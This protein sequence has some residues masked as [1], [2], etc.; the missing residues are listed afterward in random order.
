MTPQHLAADLG[1]DPADP[2]VL[3][4]CTNL[5]NNLNDAAAC[6]KLAGLT[7][8]EVRR[9][10]VDGRATYEEAEA[11]FQVWCVG[12]TEYRWHDGRPQRLVSTSSGREFW[13]TC[14]ALG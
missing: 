11:Y 9:W 13:V 5:S 14:S 4:T 12:K 3:A 7:L 10:V 6:R 2:I 1:L 8:N